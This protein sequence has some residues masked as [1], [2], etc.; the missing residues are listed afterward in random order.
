MGKDSRYLGTILGRGAVKSPMGLGPAAKSSD[1]PAKR[2][3]KKALLD[4]EVHGIPLTFSGTENCES[5]CVARECVWRVI[6]VIL[7]HGMLRNGG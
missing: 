7:G 4:P 5:G 2:R 3:Q 1:G 6:W